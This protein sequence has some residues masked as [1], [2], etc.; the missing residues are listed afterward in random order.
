[1]REKVFSNLIWRFGERILAQLISFV[2]TIVLARILSPTDYGIVAL[3]TVI[4]TILQILVDGG[5]GNALI[6]KENAD[7][8][9]F[10]SV[11]Y[12]NIIFCLVLYAG[13]FF[14]SPAIANFYSEPKMSAMLRVLGVLII[15][16]GVKNIQQAYISRTLQFKKFFWAT[17]TGTLISGVVGIVLALSGMGAWALI[18][19]ILTN[20]IID[21]V[22]I[23]ITVKWRPKRMFSFRRLKSLFSYG[24]KL[25]VSTL[26]DTL[27]GNVR[28]LIIG[29]IYSSSDLAYYNRGRYI[30]NMIVINVNTSIDSVLFP[31]M[32]N[33]QSDIGKL[34]S[35]AQR[36]IKVSN[37]IMSPMMMGIAFL[38][39]PI[40]KLLLTD[41]WLPCVPFVRIFC[42][43]YM[44]QPIQT[45]NT[46]IIKAL[47][48][49]DIRLKQEVI[50]KTIGLLLLLISLKY[51]VLMIAYA[52]LLGNFINQFVN[53]FPSKKLI[54][55]SYWEQLR[56]IMPSITLSIVMGIIVYLFS[57]VGL[58][59]C[60]K[61]FVQIAVGVIIYIL[62]SF[63]FK[64][65][66]FYYLLSVLRIFERNKNGN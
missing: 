61:L 40:I 66:S 51:G 22:I 29:K 32:S 44:F 39:E 27:Y 1:M 49:S 53:S 6:Q 58:P 13:V 50:T 46:N 11:F 56:D 14:L 16:S 36:S 60:L 30:P 65:D 43:L 19:Q 38:A 26:I 8:L 28:Q 63:V 47:G 7:D 33:Y 15:V 17:L 5:F 23:W 62:G 41:K 34:K 10:S 21:T 18:A 37:Y 2:V 52:Y 48:Y 42:I 55:Y 54:G 9:D 3:L 57:F 45:V 59:M 24:W 20:A 64:I 4:S 12:F 25:L 31:T 35:M